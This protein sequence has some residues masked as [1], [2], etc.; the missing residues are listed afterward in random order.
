MSGKRYRMNR[1]FNPVTGKTLVLP[2]DQGLALGYIDK[3]KNP[4]SMVEVYRELDIDGF[5]M[6]F[7]MFRQTEHLLAYRMAPVRIMTLDLHFDNGEIFAESPVVTVEMALKEGADAVKVLMPWRRDPQHQIKVV[8]LVSKMIQ[9]ANRWELPIVVEPV[10]RDSQLTLQER[11]QEEANACRIAVEL[12]ADILKI[13]YPG[14]KAVMQ[15]WARNFNVP[16]VLLGGPLSG[17]TDSLLAMLR[18]AIDAGARGVIV[19]RNVW[20]RGLEE[21]KRILQEVADMVHR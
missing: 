13:E 12:G 14:D 18:D 8:A 9:E 21:S 2:I 17:T 16:I 15:E 11:V 5:L 6:S 4:V 1:I 10:V 19:G 7:G 20:G 3:L